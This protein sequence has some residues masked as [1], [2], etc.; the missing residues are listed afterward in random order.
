M[1][2]AVG[3]IAIISIFVGIKKFAEDYWFLE[4]ENDEQAQEYSEML[5]E[6]D[7]LDNELDT[8]SEDPEYIANE[9]KEKLDEYYKERNS[10]KKKMWLS[11]GFSII[12]PLFGF[13]LHKLI[14]WIMVYK[15]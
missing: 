3:G 2:F 9:I 1:W 15:K 14:N 11:I 13:A 12:C 8:K 10:R 6:L 7:Q 4:V 5:A